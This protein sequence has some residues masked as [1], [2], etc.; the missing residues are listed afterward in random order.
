MPDRAIRPRRCLIVGLGQ[1]GAGYDIEAGPD[2]GVY[3]HARAIALHPDFELAGG[4]DPV[5]S[6]R[7]RFEA[8][9]GVKT[10]DGIA[11]AM[12]A[13]RPDIVVV[14]TPADM[15]LRH[16]EDVLAAGRP[17]VLICEKPLAFDEAEG[18]RLVRLCEEAGA[19]LF[20]NFIRRS[21]PGAIEVRRRIAAGDI[22]APV[23][24]TFWY[25]KGL[26]NNG[27]HFVN[28]LQFWL[29]EVKEH[30][31][32]DRGRRWADADPE[33]DVRLR[34][35]GG[36]VV[37]QAAW[38]EAFS[39]Y[40]GE[41]LSPTGRLS[42]REGGR[43]IG[44]QGVRQNENFSG[45][46]ILSQQAETIAGDMDRYQWHVYEQLSHFLAGKGFQLCDGREAL[47]TLK[48]VSAIAGR[49]GDA[50]PDGDTDRTR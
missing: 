41:L 33:P 40:G 39:F 44:W 3:T 46:R 28:L 4:V 21:D 38:E 14:A 34:F 2:G 26:F 9:Y 6:Q 45:Y 47:A 42:Y 18:E 48:V 43:A 22:A 12:D 31:V 20:V 7:D 13:E 11:A 32:L 25:S 36:A 35:E 37:M 30:V 5:A 1:I 19:A 49:Y 17:E 23:K 8:R 29:G 27:S 15:H 16:V 50:R 10:Y 24:G